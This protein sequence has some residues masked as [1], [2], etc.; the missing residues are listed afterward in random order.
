MSSSVWPHSTEATSSLDIK[1]CEYY[2]WGI[3]APNHSSE[4]KLYIFQE[5]QDIMNY[6]LSKKDISTLTTFQ[7][8]NGESFT[9]Q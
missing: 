3:T 8:E 1:N 4:L 7:A 5:K 9:Y 6:D 2:Q